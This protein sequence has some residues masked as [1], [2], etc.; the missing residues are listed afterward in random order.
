M[1]KD[2]IELFWEKVDKS[3]E[4]WTWTASKNCHGYGRVRIHGKEFSAHRA[5]WEFA[6]G[7][8]PPGMDLDHICHTRAC[9]RPDHLRVATRKQNSENVS[10]VRSSTG[11]RNVYWDSRDKKYVV[12]VGHNGKPYFAGSF[13]DIA[14]AEQAAIALR[15]QLFTHNNLDKKAA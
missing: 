10:V 4:C 14:A 13:R 7:T 2:P 6:N 15:N 12:R 11:V 9:V 8:I 1:K 3:G 5:S